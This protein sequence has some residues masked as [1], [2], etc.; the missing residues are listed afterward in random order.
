MRYVY[1]C[2]LTPDEDGSYATSF[3]DV[4]EAAP[5]RGTSS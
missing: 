2:A 1:P 5:C 3:P 4:P